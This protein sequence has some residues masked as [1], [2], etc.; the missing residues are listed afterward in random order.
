MAEPGGEVLTVRL[1]E[2]APMRL[3]RALSLAVPER[4]GLSRSRLKALIAAGAVRLEGREVSDPAA[5]VAGGQ[6]EITL[7]PP[8]P[9]AMPAQAMALDIVHED[10]ELIV[11]NKPA[12]M[13]VHPGAGR[14]DGTLVNALL[15][16]AG[17]A[18]SSVGGVARPGI[19]HR[20]DKDTSGLLVIARSDRA[21]QALAAQFAA[22]SVERHYAALCFGLPERGAPRLAGLPAVGFEP[23]GVIRIDAP[24]GRHP[25]DRQ[26]M[27]VVAR[28]GRRAVTR[29]RVE[30]A[31]GR[32]AALLDCWLETGRTHQI[33]VHLAHVGH[34][35]VGDPVYARGR[36]PAARELS[37]TA[38]AALAGFPRQALHART[39]GFVHPATGEWMRFESPLPADFAALISALDAAGPSDRTDSC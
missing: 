37:A 25:S 18:L 1:P 13:V 36:M 7:P 6:A 27:A 28:G 15:A 21:H 39:L 22:H 20:I 19:V 3:D 23:G 17:G 2:G 32:A 34:P 35:L 24:I 14:P 9:A 26:R 5:K 11:V 16:H 30:R 4:A 33:R 31:Y 12:G 38:R 10:D 29:A 8:M